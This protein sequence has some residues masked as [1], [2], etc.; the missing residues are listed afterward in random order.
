[1]MMPPWLGKMASIDPTPMVSARPP[2]PPRRSPPRGREARATSRS[3]WDWRLWWVVGLC[4]GLGYGVSFRLL[5]LGAAERGGASQRFDVQPFPGTPLESLRERFGGEPR[6][7]R[8]DL[9]QIEQEQQQQQDQA[10][11]EKRR[12]AIEERAA[13]ERRQLLEGPN[14]P[15]S[16]EHGASPPAEAEPPMAPV[17]PPPQAPPVSEREAAGPPPAAPPPL[18]PP[19]TPGSK[20]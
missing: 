5:N 1:M 17:L 4:F 11:I 12:A 2:S 7:I 8:G 20:P 18:A 10:D 9:D 14:A 19:P 6:D 13:R 15:L 3:G 16:G